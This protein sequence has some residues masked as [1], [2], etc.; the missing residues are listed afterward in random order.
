MKTQVIA[1]HVLLVED[2]PAEREALAR[3]V[4]AQGFTVASA[5]TLQEARQL[6]K[7][8]PPGMILSDLMLP[9]GSGLDLLDDVRESGDSEFIL[10]TGNASVE[11][12]VQALRR[13]ATDYVVKPIEPVHLERI[14]AGA[15]RAMKLRGEIGSLRNR[16]RELG[17]LDRKSVV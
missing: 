15:L 17:H 13:G 4:G 7:A 6:I 16:L 10:I 5:G 3:I 12:A 1:P 2:E 8:Q 14:L 11:T 9:D